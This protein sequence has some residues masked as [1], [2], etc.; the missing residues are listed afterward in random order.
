MTCRVCRQLVHG[1]VPQKGVLEKFE[2]NSTKPRQQCSFN[3]VVQGEQAH[4][5]FQCKQRVDMDIADGLLSERVVTGIPCCICDKNC[6]GD[7]ICYHCK[8]YVHDGKCSKKMQLVE[9]EGRDG[10]PGEGL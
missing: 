5:C 1:F 7:I 8:L 6:L 10:T 2:S 4:E 3:V 9:V